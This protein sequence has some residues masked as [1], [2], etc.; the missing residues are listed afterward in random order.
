M[1]SLRVPL[2]P[3]EAAPESE[4]RL[5][6]LRSLD[7]ALELSLRRL[8]ERTDWDLAQVWVADE[9]G[10]RLDCSS[11]HH[12][13]SGRLVAFRKR[14]E[15]TRFEPGG[16]LP[17]TAWSSGR[18]VWLEEVS[19]SDSRCSRG[20]LAQERV[21]EAGVAVRVVAEDEFV[22]VLE[23]LKLESWPREQW[24]AETVKAGAVE[25]GPLVR[26]RQVEQALRRSAEQFRTVAENAVDAIVSADGLGN[27]TYFNRAA[28]RIFGYRAGQ[29]LGESLRLVMPERFPVIDAEGSER[30]LTLGEASLIG[31]TFEV[32][33]RRREGGDF[34]VEVA[35]SSWSVGGETFFTAI[36][37]DITE[38]KLAQESLTLSELRYRTLAEDSTNVICVS[39]P[40]AVYTYVSPACRTLFG[41]EPDELVGSSAQDFC[42]PDDLEDLQHAY[43]AA[44]LSADL[45]TFAHRFRRRDGVYCWIESVLRQMRDPVSGDIVE[46]QASVRDITERKRAEDELRSVAASLEA[47]NQELDHF[48]T[49]ASH[50]LQEPLRKIQAFGDRLK[51]R[52]EGV[53]DERGVDYLER[54]E[55]A[56]SRMRALIDNLLALSRVT[57]KAQPFVPV[58]LDELAHAVVSDL[59]LL[60][61]DS[62]GRVEVGRL[63]T[64]DA[65]PLQ[66]RQLIQNLIANSLKFRREEVTPVIKV[67][68][69][70]VSGDGSETEVE[71]TRLFFEDNGIGFEEKYLD[72][73]FSAFERLHGRS[74]YAGTGMGLAICKKIVLHHG[75]EITA[76]SAPGEGATFIA[77]LPLRQ[78]E[79]D[80]S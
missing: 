17:G 7:S 46:V 11:V 12:D 4:A 67:Y 76:R 5:E 28:E 69:E 44:V 23:L 36:V 50:D 27:I 20:A 66:M 54:M 37:R 70:P 72:R 19:A 22:G 51:S 43:R 77:T 41:Y 75:G 21:P 52:Y 48:A 73:I 40:N 32:E 74:Q 80:E 63:P 61:G 14:S 29:A 8:C 71:M 26:R 53:L 39:D 2:H 45:V 55:S 10:S 49:V 13:A 57:T 1:S 15:S 25:I 6:D 35:L 42:H 78:P 18:L 65:D 34:P 38:R 59:E 24:L 60:I 47:S 56:A 62:N 64:I 33:G 31:R 58:D 79:G 9:G 3:A 68:S 16:G 30:L